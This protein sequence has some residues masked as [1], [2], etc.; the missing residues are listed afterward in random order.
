MALATNS[1]ADSKTLLAKY[2]SLPQPED[3]IQVMYVWIDGS[4][5]NLRCK[6]MT[7]DREPLRPEGE[8]LNTWS[9]SACMICAMPPPHTGLNSTLA[10][11]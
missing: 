6:T 1:P 10:D 8:L 11:L 9:N 2:Y 5:E 4:G 3:K 7:V